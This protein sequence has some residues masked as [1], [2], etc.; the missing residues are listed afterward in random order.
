MLFGAG[1]NRLKFSK[2]TSIKTFSLVQTQTK[3]LPGTIVEGEFSMK[4]SSS[5][6]NLNN[7]KVLLEISWTKNLILF[8]DIDTP[9]AYSYVEFGEHPSC[10]GENKHS[11]AQTTIKIFSKS[12]F[13]FRSIWILHN[14]IEANSLMETSSTSRSSGGSSKRYW[15]LIFRLP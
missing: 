14:L 3:P 2:Q 10:G 4:Q 1:L 6:W 9:Q 15:I 12:F 11:S 7:K 13:V 5:A 8:Y